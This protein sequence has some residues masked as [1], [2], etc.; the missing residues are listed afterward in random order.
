M[1]L[2][3]QQHLPADFHPDSRVWIYQSD[4]L[5]TKGEALEINDVLNVFAESWKTHGDKVKGCAQ[6]FFDMFIIFMAD[7][8]ATSV[9]GCSTDSSVRVVKDIE[10]KY[11][12]NLF[13]RQLLTFYKEDQLIQI[14][15]NQFESAIQENLIFQNDLYFNNTIS[16]KVE[17]ETKWIIPL[18]DSWL[19]KYITDEKNENRLHNNPSTIK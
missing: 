7:E 2:A 18:K 11:G 19:S 8:K 10:K 5:F 3:F 6:L 9:S 16:T 4:R 12:V 14:P 1:N 15:L 17:M 13:N